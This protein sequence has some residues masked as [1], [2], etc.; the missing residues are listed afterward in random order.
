MLLVSIVHETNQLFELKH[1]THVCLSGL[2]SS[3]HETYYIMIHFGIVLFQ[4]RETERVI[5]R[6]IHI[7][8]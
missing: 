4:N 7:Y 8:I 1:E 3:I 6:D 2:T 5:N